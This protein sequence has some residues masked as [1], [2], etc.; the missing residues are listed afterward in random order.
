MLT[1]DIGDPLVGRGWGLAPATAAASRSPLAVPG[2]GPEQ[3]GRSAG[4]LLQERLADAHG[5][6]SLVPEP[7]G[8]GVRRIDGRREARGLEPDGVQPPATGKPRRLRDRLNYARSATL[9]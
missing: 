4:R 9:N 6:N 2:D 1:V 7:D 3:S 8:A 5:G